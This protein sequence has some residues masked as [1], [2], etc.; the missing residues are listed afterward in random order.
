MR[1]DVRG[2]SLSEFDTAKRFGAPIKAGRRNVSPLPRR[3]RPRRRSA[4]RERAAVPHKM[5]AVSAGAEGTGRMGSGRISPRGQRR[6]QMSQAQPWHLQQAHTPTHG[7][8]R[9][10][11]CCSMP[12]ERAGPGAQVCR[13]TP[14]PGF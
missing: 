13:V 3:P 12:R 4:R 2:V 6:R 7:W 1:D 14:G 8:Y 9:R 11:A 10:S 5:P